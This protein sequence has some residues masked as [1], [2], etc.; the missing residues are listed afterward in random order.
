MCKIPGLDFPGYKVVR[1][2]EPR[3]GETFVS[4]TGEIMGCVGNTMGQPRLILEK[5]WDW[6]IWL[7]AK[8]IT[9]DEDGTWFAYKSEPTIGPENWYTEDGVAAALT[10]LDLEGPKCDDWTNSLMENPHGN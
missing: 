6:P 8:Y 10:V 1:F 5:L 4:G 7:K 3:T 2:G 9:M